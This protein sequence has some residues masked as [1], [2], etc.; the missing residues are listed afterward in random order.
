MMREAMTIEAHAPEAVW[1]ESKTVGNR[2]SFALFLLGVGGLVFAAVWLGI[3][4]TRAGDLVA[5]LW[6]ANAVA[7]AVL[8][9]HPQGLHA[10]TIATIFVANVA[11]RYAVGDGTLVAVGLAACNL[12]EVT[13]AVLLMQRGRGFFA[14]MGESGELARLV[15]FAS[16]C[17]PAVSAILAAQLVSVDQGDG[18]VQLAQR[19]FLAHCLGMITLAPLLLALRRTMIGQMKQ[20]RAGLE[21]FMMTALAVAVVATTFSHPTYPTLFAIFPVLILAAFR[22]RFVGTSLTVTLVSLIATVLTI[23]GYGPIAG[24]IPEMADRVTF[25][26]VFLAIAALTTLPVAAVLLERSK[27]QQK[28]VVATHD[29]KQAANAK[30][31]FLA[32]MSHEIRTPLTGVL[33]MIELLRSNPSERDRIR[34]FASLQLSANLLMT[35]LNDILDFSKLDSGKITFGDIPFDLR[36]LAQATL[37]L[38]HGAAQAKCLSLEL[39]YAT[40]HTEVCG[41]PVRLQQI[42][43]NLV[44]NAIKFTDIGRIDLRVE[45]KAPENGK[46]A[47]T[48]SVIDSGIGIAPE[49]LDQLFSPFVQADTSTNRRFGG[50]GLGLAIC[51]RLVEALCGK[52][53]VESIP[54]LGSTFRFK[55]DLDRGQVNENIP[56]IEP[57]ATSRRLLKVLLAE[58]NPVN[59]L[60]ITTLL[61][62]MGHEVETAEN[63]LLAVEAAAARR[64]DVILM[65]MQMPEMDGIAATRAIRATALGATIPIIAL[66]A[67]ASPDRRRFY[68][69]VGL[70]GFMT[71]PVDST[72]LRDRLAAIAEQLPVKDVTRLPVLDV[73]RLDE[74]GEAIGSGKVDELL[75]LLLS[76]LTVRR[77]K[78]VALAEVAATLPLKAELHALRGAAASVGAARLAAAIQ[79]MEDGGDPAGSTARTLAFSCAAQDTLNEIAS[80]KMVAKR[81]LG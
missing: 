78:I 33:G 25:L 61:R 71:K 3:E 69:N 1:R 14:G 30:S 56:A 55:I 23:N 63:G 18:F 27:L 31:A 75:D 7:L 49:Q 73:A 54:G 44:S 68:D 42:M 20:A 24:A 79:T 10:I 4:L 9:R 19:W 70:T 40:D 45:T 2:L 43:G 38:Y 65:D 64:Y 22:L 77:A 15:L 46:V 58:D 76:D 39:D 50:T 60:L 41:D 57:S 13:L 74:L 35:V 51:L 8:L 72:V 21:P 28:L 32:T 5:S 59:R 62:R 36:H 11:A 17:A 53:E 12:V 34:F 81:K 26:Q 47:A 52:L 6:L 80:R 66:T 48:F 29:A 16:L 67:D 37:D